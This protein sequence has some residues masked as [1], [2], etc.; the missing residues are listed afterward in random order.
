MCRNNR[1]QL[2]NS[3]PIIVLHLH[4]PLQ[5]LFNL[6][7]NPSRHENTQKQQNKKDI[8]TKHKLK[9]H[10]LSK[11]EGKIL[12]KILLDLLLSCN[13][14][15]QDS[16]SVTTSWKLL[17]ILKMNHSTHEMFDMILPIINCAVFLFLTLI[18]V[19]PFSSDITMLC[20]FQFIR[21]NTYHTTGI[22]L[23]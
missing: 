17:L 13:D 22:V 3:I 10:S 5:F 6:S 15:Y 18:P 14:F 8:S 9:G 1:K 4:T 23:R 7:E 12:L 16:A 2:T 20:N 11:T 21:K 19:D